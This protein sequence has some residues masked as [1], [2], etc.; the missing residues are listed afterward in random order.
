MTVARNGVEPNLTRT[1]GM[2]ALR[3]FGRRLPGSG[4]GGEAGAQMSI[5]AP[6]STA[7][8]AGMRKKR[9]ASVAAS[10]IAM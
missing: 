7:R 10:A 8:S 1:V 4:Q 6:I 9:E 5:L 2:P 3:R